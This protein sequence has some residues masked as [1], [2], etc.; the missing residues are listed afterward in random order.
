MTAR[1]P[2]ANMSAS[3]ALAEFGRY[4]AEERRASDKTVEAYTRDIAHFIGFLNEHLGKS[5][6]VRDLEKLN[7]H[8]VIAWLAH[9]RSHD[10]LVASSRARAAS[11][12]RAFFRFL[13]RKLDAP[14]ARAMMFESPRRPHRLPR[15]LPEQMAEKS[16]EAAAEGPAG[17]ETPEW[18]LAR[19]A[20][21][22]ALLYGAGLRLSEALSLTGRDTPAPE[23][24][25][26]LGKG[27]KVRM[28]PLIRPVRR[29]V[30]AYANLVPF[31]LKPDEPLF[32]GVKGGPLNPRMVQRLMERVRHELGLPE[33]AT[34]HALRHSFATHL[35]ANGGDLRSIQALLGHASL[36]TTQIYTGVDAARLKAVHA[37]AHPRA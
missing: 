36:S 31:L 5:P 17:N 20:A 7:R 19:D 26:I 35:L 3:E 12:L 27:R 8:D 4:L 33:T 10:N 1:P 6:A 37:E 30:D 2:S 32:R 24:L 14:N 16:I 28:V 23:A 18:A 21:I 11:S 22:I 9:R 13:D 15:P 34:P 29:A 25:R